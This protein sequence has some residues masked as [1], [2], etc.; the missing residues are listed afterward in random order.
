M[1][2]T[3]H[4][5]LFA[6]AL[7]L[8]GTSALIACSGPVTPSGD[9]ASDA[10]GDTVTRA[11]AA[12]CE[13]GPADVAQ[14]PDAPA[15]DATVADV[16]TPMDGTVLTDSGVPADVRTVADSSADASASDSAADVV[17]SD[18]ADADTCPATAPMNGTACAMG[19]QTCSWMEPGGAFT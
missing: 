9:A 16:A 2:S 11:E 13:A 14:Q 4:F 7:A 15:A 6:R 12:C 17:T 10:G 1:S 8:V 3:P 5:L 19:G 18:V